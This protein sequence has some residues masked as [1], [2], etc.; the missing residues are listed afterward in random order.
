MER[1]AKFAT[2]CSGLSP[3]AKAH[4]CRPS[5]GGIIGLN[6]RL[7][8]DG[9]PSDRLVINGGT[10]TGHRAGSFSVVRLY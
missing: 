9:S 5:S 3:A 10:A 6:T 4:V 2:T 7:D 8:T 1:C